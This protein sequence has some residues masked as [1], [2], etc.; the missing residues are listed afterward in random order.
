[1]PTDV[2]P[3]GSVGVLQNCIDITTITALVTTYNYATADCDYN[4]W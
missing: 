3:T 4:P 2:S 1:M